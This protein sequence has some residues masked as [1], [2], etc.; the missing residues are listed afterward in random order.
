MK[1]LETSI[2]NKLKAKSGIIS[3]C[4]Y[5][6]E[7]ICMMNNVQVCPALHIALKATSG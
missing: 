4:T 5:N 3:L 6:N 1:N 2:Q 7:N